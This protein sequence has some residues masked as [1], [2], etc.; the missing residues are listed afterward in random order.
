[1]DIKIT[2][3]VK[4]EII[5]VIFQNIKLFN[6]NVNIFFKED[7]V[8]IQTMDS[9]HISIFEMNIPSKWFDEYKVEKNITIGVNTNL[10]FKILTTREKIQNI[11]FH[12]NIDTDD[13]LI[14]NFYNDKTII[15]KSFEVPLMD[16]ETEQL[17]IPDMEYESEFSLPSFNMFQLVQQLKLFGDN[18][19]IDCSEE[20]I[21]LHTI[22]DDAGKMT[23][24]IKIDD[25]TA[26]EIEEDAELKFSFG[27]NQLCN[28]MQFNK[29]ASH[30]NISLKTGYPLK[31]KFVISDKDEA[32]V[33]MYLAPKI[34]DE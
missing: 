25:L 21:S 31:A 1:M 19:Q 11:H 27:L 2:D 26:F 7:E 23:A 10:I 16:L 22:T 33:N 34:D 29:I 6:D 8:Y 4:C 9:A 5:H 30:V 14:M 24:T 12:M 3:L 28:I 13:K 32:F 20:Q 17:N 15:N 18:I